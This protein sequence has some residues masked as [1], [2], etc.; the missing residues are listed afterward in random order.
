MVTSGAAPPS[1]TTS[2][3]SQLLG[4][5]QQNVRRIAALALALRGGRVAGAGL[6][7]DRL[8]DRP[9]QIARDVDCE[10]LERGNVE[11]V[12]PALAAQVAAGGE[13]AACWPSSGRKHGALPSPLWGGVGGGGR[14]L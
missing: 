1:A 10:R 13:Q 9:L 7:P 2:S 11:R 8:G 6:D 12:Q 4:R 5:S 14:A 3:A